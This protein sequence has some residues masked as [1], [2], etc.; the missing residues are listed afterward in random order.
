LDSEK[1][2]DKFYKVTMDTT[3]VVA[4]YE[5]VQGQ[6]FLFGTYNRTII[7]NSDLVIDPS[8]FSPIM[9]QGFWIRYE[10]ISRS[11]GTISLG[12][13]GKDRSLLQWTD[14]EPTALNGTEHIGFEVESGGNTEFGT[15]CF[16][17]L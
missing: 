12:K 15:V 2:P 17:V 1:S 8:E 3:G 4:I 10:P 7:R 5:N 11:Q 9:F 13:L 16:D 6:A 14:T